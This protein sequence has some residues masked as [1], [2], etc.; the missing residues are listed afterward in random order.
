MKRKTPDPVLPAIR[1]LARKI[2]TKPLWA[3]W[4]LLRV[5]FFTITKPTQADGMRQFENH[6]KHGWRELYLKDKE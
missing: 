2:K 6:P 4:A 3:T 1:L 5:Q